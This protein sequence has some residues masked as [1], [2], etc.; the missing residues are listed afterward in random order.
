MGYKEWYDEGEAGCA[1]DG[2][3]LL[4]RG[5]DGNDE[6]ASAQFEQTAG[7]KRLYQE[8]WKRGWRR[9]Q[10]RVVMGDGAE[11]IWNLAAEHFPEAI[12]IVDLYHALAPV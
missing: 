9:A 3:P 2:K 1:G 11:W 5:V 6:G 7:R 12:Q 8:A 10:K 4:P